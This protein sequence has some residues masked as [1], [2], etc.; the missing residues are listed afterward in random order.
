MD[1]A[2]LGYSLGQQQQ[3]RNKSLSE[4]LALG[5]LVRESKL[6]CP[7]LVLKALTKG[8]TKA[9]C[10]VTAGVKGAELLELWR[11]A[12]GPS[13]LRDTRHSRKY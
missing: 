9:K 10:I 13:S 2:K 6:F 8:R 11:K 3:V 1:E 7:P 4:T 5:T 12:G